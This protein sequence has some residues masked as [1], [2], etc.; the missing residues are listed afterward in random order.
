MFIYFSKYE[1]QNVPTNTFPFNWLLYS[2]SALDISS[3]T[4][5][6]HVKR[7]RLSALWHVTTTFPSAQLDNEGNVVNSTQQFSDDPYLSTPI[8][9]FL[10]SYRYWP[11]NLQYLFRSLHLWRSLQFNY[12][13]IRTYQRCFSAS[14]MKSAGESD[15]LI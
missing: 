6:G 11:T 10:H 5:S 2:D 9:W 3:F 7:P 8:N 4:K 15:L 14:I 12:F 1:Q 13:D